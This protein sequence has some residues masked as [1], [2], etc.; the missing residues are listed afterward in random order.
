ML[1]FLMVLAFCAFCGLLPP[2]RYGIR[3]CIAIVMV[4]AT[5]WAIQH[6][7]HFDEPGEWWIAL[8]LLLPCIAVILTGM[9]LRWL[10]KILRNRTPR[11]PTRL[12]KLDDEILLFADGVLGVLAG[13]CGGLLLALGLAVAMRGFPG[14]LMLHLALFVAAVATAVFALCYLRGP[15]RSGAVTTLL[16]LAGFALLGGLYWPTLV[17]RAAAELH[18]GR[19][20]CLRAVDRPAEPADTMLFSMPRGRPGAPGL[21]L[22]VKLPNREWRD[23]RWS[24]RAGGFV[25]YGAYRHG[26]CPE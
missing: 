8:A 18:R 4:I 19:P 12:S 16:V 15:L 9:A 23:Y 14:G 6:D 17:E 3:L 11:R 26:P 7:L 5:I 21:I 24:Y 2:A 25:S 13:I 22:T 1:A 10:W 20:S